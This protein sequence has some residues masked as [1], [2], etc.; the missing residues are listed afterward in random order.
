MD[1]AAAGARGR[2][3]LRSRQ[4]RAN[5]PRIQDPALARRQGRQ[6]LQVLPARDLSGDEAG[7]RVDGVGA[8]P[9]FADDSAFS[10]RLLRR[11]RG[12]ALEVGLFVI[13]T[14]LLPA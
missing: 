4:R 5:P 2:D 3:Q 11:A 10:T 1:L 6:G 9:L 13:L 8:G 12:L 7:M 14:P